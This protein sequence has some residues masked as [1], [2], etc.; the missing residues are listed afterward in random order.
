MP[1]TI[2]GMEKPFSISSD[3]PGWAP[4]WAHWAQPIQA[5][6]R[7]NLDEGLKWARLEISEAQA[8]IYISQMSV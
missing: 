1:S 2:N 8:C 3:V 5:R 6:A 4:T 7:P